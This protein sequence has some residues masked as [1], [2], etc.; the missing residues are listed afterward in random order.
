ML[1]FFIFFSGLF[2]LMLVRKH[3]LLS[4]LSLEFI[5]LSIFFFMYYFFFFCFFDFFFGI[6]F[7]VLGVC[8]G[9]LGLSL[10]VYL[11]RS[12]DGCY[13]DSLILC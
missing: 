11:F 6:V 13:V 1:S 12:S 3:F 2:S 9:V 7:L 4:L 5:I 10:I 8:E